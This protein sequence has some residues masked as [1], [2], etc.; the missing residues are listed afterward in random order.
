MKTYYKVIGLLSLSLGVLGV[1]LPLLPTTC[2]VLFSAWCFAKSSPVW[3]QRL[4]DNT[5]FGPII[6]QWEQTRCISKKGQLLALGS[7][8][9]FGTLSFVFME[10][11]TLRILLVLLVVAGVVTVLYL[12]R[13]CLSSSCHS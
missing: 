11:M 5:L 9:F 7:M 10:D 8:L 4:C 12:S 6:N 2:F 13:R 3:H 1:F